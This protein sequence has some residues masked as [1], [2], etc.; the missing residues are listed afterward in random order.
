M[1]GRGPTTIYAVSWR[2]RGNRPQIT[3]V[4]ANSHGRA[5]LAVERNAPGKIVMKPSV[6]DLWWGDNDSTEAA[7]LIWSGGAEW[8]PAE[9]S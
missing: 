1:S 3:L 5:L 9:E 7:Y 2:D 6:C 4:A 8:A